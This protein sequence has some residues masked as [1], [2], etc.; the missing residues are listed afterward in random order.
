MGGIRQGSLSG[1]DGSMDRNPTVVRPSPSVVGS[2]IS[3]HL[4]SRV[5]FVFRLDFYRNNLI[6]LSSEVVKIRKSAH[7]TIL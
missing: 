3:R 4:S 2:G 7:F 1:E 5:R 6:F